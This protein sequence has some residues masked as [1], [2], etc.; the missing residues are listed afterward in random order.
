MECRLKFL[1]NSS[2]PKQCENLPQTLA[3]SATQRFSQKR[4]N[5]SRIERENTYAGKAKTAE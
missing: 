4:K 2:A 5:L 1:R 3:S